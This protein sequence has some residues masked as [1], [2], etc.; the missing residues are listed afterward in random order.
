MK[1]VA[2]LTQFS[3][4]I[5]KSTSLELIVKHQ[6][7]EKQV[8]DVFENGKDIRKNIKIQKRHKT[9]LYLVGKVEK[10]G[11]LE[12]GKKKTRVASNIN[13]QMHE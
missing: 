4:K 11:S 6:R 13:C 2:K 7:K 10:I 9:N 8:A 1:L 5:N 3:L 12:K